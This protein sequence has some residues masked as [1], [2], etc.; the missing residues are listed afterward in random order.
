MGHSLPT[1]PLF[2]A[3]TCNQIRVTL[4]QVVTSQGGYFTSNNIND[5]DEHLLI[6]AI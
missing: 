2:S 6:V 5:K 1:L 3:F 4:V